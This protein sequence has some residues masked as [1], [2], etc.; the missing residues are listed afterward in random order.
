MNE[1]LS[2]KISIYN[3]V[4]TMG[5]VI[6]HC[7]N[8]NLLYSN[9]QTA[10][11]DIMYNLY[12][13]IG[14]ISMCFFFMLSAYLFYVGLNSW[15]D[16]CKKMKKRVITLGVPFLVWNVIFL[17]Y[18]IFYGVIKGSL[19]LNASDLIF[20]FSFVPFDGPLWYVFALL[21]LMIV[22]PLVYALKKYPGILLTVVIIA[23][24]GCNA[25]KMLV[26]SDNT[27]IQWF[28]RLFTYVPIYLFGAYLGLCKSEAVSKEKYRYKLF[29]VLSAIV[30]LLIIACFIFCKQKHYLLNSALMFVLPIAVWMSTY[31]SMY[32]KIKIRYPLKITFFV[33]CM[34]SLLI[35]IFNTI[36]TKIVGNA[37]F[38]PVLSFFAHFVFLAALYG[39]C[40]ATA[41]VSGKILPPKLYFA[42]SGGRIKSLKK[43]KG[44][45]AG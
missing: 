12:D 13:L 16:L 30:S 44:I 28:S 32:E 33:Y 17:S 8:F 29:A 7:K 27:I 35:G 24:A 39:F 36:L 42:L 18:N 6:Y 41:Y 9:K 1:R 34:H 4:F 26:V 37:C 2:K 40:L 19:N 14:S 15:V 3:F 43:Q 38:H 25:W 22:S 20:G 21:L 10:F 5:I 11:L 45:S 23:F 31:I